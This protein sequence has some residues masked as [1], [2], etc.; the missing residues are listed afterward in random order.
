LNV[1]TKQKKKRIHS[2]EKRV[3]PRDFRKQSLLTNIEKGKKDWYSNF[4]DGRKKGTV[5]G[6][7]RKAIR[8][9]T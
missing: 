6:V 4:L 2:W 1:S 8:N 9:I 3:G 5:A 7:G